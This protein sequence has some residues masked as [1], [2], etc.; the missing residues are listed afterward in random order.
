[1]GL[2]RPYIRKSTLEALLNTSLK[3]R[4]GHW[5]DANTGEEII[6]KFDIGHVSGHEF[7]REKLKAEAEG[8]TQAEFNERMNNPEYYQLETPAN[9]RSHEFEYERGTFAQDD[10]EKYKAYLEVMEEYD[11]DIDSY[12]NPDEL[13]DDE[14]L[15]LEA[16]YDLDYQEESSEVTEETEE[17]EEIEETTVT[18]ETTVEETVE[19]EEIPE[20]EVSETAVSAEISETVETIE[21]S[22]EETY[23]A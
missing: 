13:T 6:G 19:V 3:S 16:R 14:L 12:V 21:E 8:L 4:N 11:E 5:I 18:E 1:M 10:P 15:E 17:V 20:P 7:W 23:T 9:N 2:H 22:S